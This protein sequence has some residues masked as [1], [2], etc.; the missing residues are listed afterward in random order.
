MVLWEKVKVKRRALVR[1]DVISKNKS[2]T[3]EK[4][5]KR[6][7]TVDTKSQGYSEAQLSD[8]KYK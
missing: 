5:R 2:K 8:D 7:K 4:E 1:S 3:K 6:G